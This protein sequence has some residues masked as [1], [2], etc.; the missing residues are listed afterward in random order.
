M[1]QSNRTFPLDFNLVVQGPQQYTN[2]TLAQQRSYNAQQQWM[3]PR[4]RSVQLNVPSPVASVRSTATVPVQQ[5]SFDGS[6]YFQSHTASL[7][8]GPNTDL[9]GMDM[10]APSGHVTRN[11]FSPITGNYNDVP[12]NAF[13][14]R[15]SDTSD[16]QT[17]FIQG[18]GNLSSFRQGPGSVGSAAHV[19][20]S[21]FFSQSAVSYDAGR[22]DQSGRVGSLSQQVSNLNV[23][24]TTSESAT[25][26]RTHSDQR[27]QISHTS[28]RSGRRDPSL[29]CAICGD[30][31][32]CNS[33]FKCV[34]FPKIEVLS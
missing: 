23:R 7:H 4:S 29:R 19:S 11:S 3:Q 15:T 8:D 12:W 28:S 16:D 21:G 25:M 27:S 13:N 34:P 2:N 1:S 18:N 20:D 10:L 14:L 26:R 5:R 30:I 17:S 6:G 32:K 9:L 22:I 31:S 33:D 24:A